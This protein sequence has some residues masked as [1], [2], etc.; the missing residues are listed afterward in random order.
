MSG[1]SQ[2]KM[3]LRVYCQYC[4]GIQA[5]SLSAQ[6]SESELN[7]IC[8]EEPVRSAL[9]LCIKTLSFGLLDKESSAIARF[10]VTGLD[11]LATKQNY[12]LTAEFSLVGANISRHDGPTIL[13]T[14]EQLVPVIHI[15]SL[16]RPDEPKKLS[17]KASAT[18]CC[19]DLEWIASFVA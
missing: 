16:G 2:L 14:I 4:Q 15:M 7:F 9:A 13:E 8:R 18:V 5:K 3:Y 10:A 12:D 19:L 11:A 1:W 6:M 17:V